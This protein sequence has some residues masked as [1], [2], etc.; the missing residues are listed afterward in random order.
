MTDLERRPPM[1]AAPNGD[2]FGVGCVVRYRAPGSTEIRTV[3]VEEIDPLL[4]GV[5][6]GF[7]G[8]QFDTESGRHLAA[9]WGWARQ[10][11]HVEQ[12]PYESTEEAVELLGHLW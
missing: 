11:F 6:P 5:E 9:V 10:V 12:G 3:L 2:L 7:A 8:R 4:E 1:L